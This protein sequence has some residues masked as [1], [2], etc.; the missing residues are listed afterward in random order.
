MS[1]NEKSMQHELPQPPTQIVIAT[2]AKEPFDWKRVFFIF[3]GLGIFLLIYYMP[4]WK[5][6]IDPG[7]KAFPLSVEGKGAIALFLMAGIWWVFEVIPIGAT[8]LAIGVFQGLFAIRPAKEAFKD[9]M[10]P[11]V[12]FIF[13]SVVVGLAFTKSGLTKRLAYKMLEVVGEKTSMILL[14]CFV[15]TA[16]LAHFM[17]HTAAAATV[18]PILMAIYAL[19]G[20]GDKP[21]NFGKALF[22]GMAYSAGAGSIITFLGA[23]RGPAAAGMFKEFTGRD[24]PFFDLPLYMGIIGWAMVFLIWAI[25]MVFLKP[26]K[27]TIPGLRDKVKRLSKEL[28]PMNFNEKFVIVAMLLVVVVMAL[29]SFVPALKSQDRASIMLLSTLL[30]FL[31]KVLTVKELED[32]PWNIILLFSGAMSIGFCLWKTGAAQWMAVNWLVMFQNAHWLVFIL[33]IAFFVLLMTNFIMNVAAIAISLPVSLV[34][35]PYLGV[36]P[37]VIF[38]ASLV[39][40][41]MP[42]VLLIGAAPNAIAYDSKQ[43]TTG[44]FFKYGIPASLILMVVLGIAIVTFWPLLGMPITIAK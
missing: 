23:A 1:N 44:E 35:A 13:G 21:T 36:A 32:I 41:G 7:G 25:L 40:A 4:P 33:S 18:F 3:L 14:G 24:I 29:Q 15:V 10:D 20:E 31:F 5:D 28:G 39:T 42:F 12:M 38:Y 34:I 19:Y 37:D 6:A 17:A 8:A 30:F 9:F 16:G 2:E 26:E 27:K 22:I 11:S 43:F